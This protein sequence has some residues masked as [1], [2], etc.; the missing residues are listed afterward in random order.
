M[1]EM[2]FVIAA[3]MGQYLGLVMTFTFHQ[4]A[5]QVHLLVHASQ[6]HTTTRQ[7]KGAAFSRVTKV[8]TNSRSGKLKCLEL[9]FKEQ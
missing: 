2:L 8:T 9:M 5:T 3:A 1:M 7:E 6:S 4:I